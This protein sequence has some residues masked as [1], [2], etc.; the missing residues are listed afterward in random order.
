MKLNKHLQAFIYNWPAKVLSL[1]FA[2]LVYA[3]IQYTTLGA[4]V[5][6]I[7]L[8]VL[9]PERYEP[10]SLVPASVE[11]SIRG[12]ED[13]IYLINPN[14]IQASVDF[15]AV[16]QEGIATAPVILVYDE[17]V[18]DSADIALSANPT[19]FRILFTA[20]SGPDD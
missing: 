18:F 7:P 15:S 4:R 10:E 19:Q 11:V 2:L 20:G 13:V 17:Q 8:E 6:T 14:S 1:V 3:F 16:K 9:L 5:V 12:N